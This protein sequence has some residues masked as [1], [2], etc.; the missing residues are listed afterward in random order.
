MDSYTRQQEFVNGL[1]SGAGVLFGIA[2]L[3]VLTGMAIGGLCTQP[4][5]SS[6][7]GINIRIRMRCGMGSCWRQLLSIM[8]RCC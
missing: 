2:G 6:I 1:I 5:Y 4:G 3:P 8:W 7:S